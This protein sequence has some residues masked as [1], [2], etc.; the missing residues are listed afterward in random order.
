[1][2]F[3]NTGTVPIDGTA[4]IQVLA[5][6]SEVVAEFQHEIVGLDPGAPVTFDDLWDTTAVLEG[7]YRIVA[8][9]S[10]AGVTTDPVLITVGTEPY[11]TY[12][13]LILRAQP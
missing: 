3:E 4:L 11:R 7:T 10:Y 6:S 8:Y 5:Q 2:T 13:P 1:M 12:L 9:V